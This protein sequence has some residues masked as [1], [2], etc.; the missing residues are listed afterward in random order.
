MTADGLNSY[1][2]DAEHRLSAAVGVTYTYDGLGR[3]GMKSSGVIYWYGAS[4]KVLL[5]TNLTG[6]I[7]EVPAGPLT[8]TQQRKHFSGGFVPL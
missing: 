3:R 4:E 8:G 1:T 5:E 6:A 7:A 2:Y